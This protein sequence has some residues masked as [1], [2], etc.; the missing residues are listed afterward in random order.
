MP[1][2]NDDGDKPRRTWRE[3][4]KNRN[5]SSHTRPTSSDRDRDRFEKSTAYSRYKQNLEKVFSGGELSES[6]RDRLDPTGSGKARDALLK[7]VREAED[8]KSFAEA[9]DALLAQGDFPDDP[10]LLDRSLDHPKPPVVLKA[11]AQLAALSADGKLAK[12]PASLKQRLASLE[13]T[14]DDPEVQDEAKALAKKLF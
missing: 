9:I 3:I 12:P 7:K 2:S 8:T 14:H 10:Y 6:M 1:R 11:L 5:K 13:L 4:D